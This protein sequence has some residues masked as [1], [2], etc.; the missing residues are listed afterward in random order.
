MGYCSFGSLVPFTFSKLVCLLIPSHSI[1]PSF[2]DT[3]W[4]S[5]LS[6]PENDLETAL[7]LVGFRVYFGVLSPPFFESD[8][9]E[10]VS[11][12]SSAGNRQKQHTNHNFAS[13]ILIETLQV[14]S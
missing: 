12:S 14:P 9:S 7:E 6:G 2:G 10:R 13:L 1:L 4:I 5:V 8:P 11:E 3:F